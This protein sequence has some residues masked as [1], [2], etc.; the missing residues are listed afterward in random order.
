MFTSKKE[1][2]TEDQIAHAYRLLSEAQY[3]HIQM[4]T[5]T[6]LVLESHKTDISATDVCGLYEVFLSNIGRFLEELEEVLF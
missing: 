4:V 2:Y 5:L 1:S 3:A 6:D